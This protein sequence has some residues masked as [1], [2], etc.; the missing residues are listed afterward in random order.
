MKDLTPE[1]KPIHPAARM[2]A[3]ECREGKLSRREFM[4]RATALGVAATTA[5]GLIGATAPSTA[6]ADTPQMG[7]SLRMQMDIKAQR[8]PRTWD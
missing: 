6:R 5:Y 1:S 3:R 2:Y 7:G 4:T 8:D